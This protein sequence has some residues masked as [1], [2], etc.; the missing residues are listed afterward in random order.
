MSDRATDDWTTTKP[1]RLFEMADQQA[2][3]TA[4]SD[5]NPMHMDPVAARRT[6]AGACVVHGVHAVLWALDTLA[7][8]GAPVANLIAV[9]VRFTKFVFVGSLVALAVKK[10]NVT[11]AA[12]ELQSNGVPAM[13]IALRFGE[14]SQAS[15]EFD[16]LLDD[17]E[18]PGLVPALRTIEDVTDMAR[19]IARP[20]DMERL[21]EMFPNL[22]TAI[23]VQR[24]SGF[25][26]LSRL[27]GMICPGLNSVFT[28]I[29]V[30][31]TEGSIA[32]PGIGFRVVAADPRFNVLRIAVGGGGLQGSVGAF[33]RHAPVEAPDMRALADQVTS[34]E[35]AGAVALIVG[36]S[37]GLG[38]ITAKL[39]A[40]GGQTEAAK[41]VDEINAF[42]NEPTARAIRFD[43][44]AAPAPQF[45][46][47]QDGITHLYYFATPQ[48][49]RQLS[50]PF[51]P[52][53]LEEFTRVYVHA[54]HDILMHAYAGA[55]D[56]HLSV[57]YPSS[58][59]VDQRPPGLTEYAMAKVAGEILCA[60]LLPAMPGL[61]ILVNR[62]P[63]ILTDQTATAVPSEYDDPIVVM[64]PLIRAV[65]HLP[66]D[67]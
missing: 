55:P 56:S 44:L 46:E 6:Q 20:A 51:T 9:D 31:L 11:S 50:V 26:L 25:A 29:R 43:A 52:A 15:T 38:A 32:R 45:A 35:F 58:V 4:S 33:M 62:L 27:V 67:A 42:R 16:S 3:A 48:I 63:R 28:A 57:F 24:I 19:W 18:D 47:L 66:K 36:G 23:G 65:Q 60:D 59:A 49:F 12:I 8:S 21:G 17:S 61:K 40:A 7:A 37:R 2:F 1:E 14:R 30:T 34:D 54:F 13:T 53:V 41:V 22:A 39:L 64:L 5:Y 10:S